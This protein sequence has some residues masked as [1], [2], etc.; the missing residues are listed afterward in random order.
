MH[1]MRARAFTAV[2]LL[3]VLWVGLPVGLPGPSSGPASVQCLTLPDTPEDPA[4]PDLIPVLEQCSALNP[5]DVE[6]MAD[7]ASS[8]EAHHRLSEAEA[9]YRRIL[10][11]D[12]GY[13]GARMKLAK[14]LLS[15]GDRIAA[16]R[17]AEAVLRVQPNRTAVLTF[18]RDTERSR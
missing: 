10:S 4:R 6:L 3:V 5:T 8:Y 13:A 18:L 1:T 2:A 12:P 15:R 9:V 14:L 7:L 11:V 17:E 16:H